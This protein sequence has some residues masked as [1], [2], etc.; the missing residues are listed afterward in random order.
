MLFEE[1]FQPY[2]NEQSSTHFIL[3]NQKGNRINHTE[4]K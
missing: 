3:N 1:G 2:L 4:D